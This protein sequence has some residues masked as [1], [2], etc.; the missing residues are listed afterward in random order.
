M[1]VLWQLERNVSIVGAALKWEGG[2]T[3]GKIYDP[4]RCFRPSNIIAVFSCRCSKWR[5]RPNPPNR[6]NSPSCLHEQWLRVISLSLTFSKGTVV[7]KSNNW[8][9]VMTS[10][11]FFIH[12]MY[13]A[14]DRLVISV[15]FI[16]PTPTFRHD[17]LLFTKSLTFL[18]TTSTQNTLHS[19]KTFASMGSMATRRLKFSS[20][21][22]VWPI[23][24]SYCHP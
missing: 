19:L 7:W 17:Q 10:E 21:N 23:P 2:F 13:P 20:P 24:R 18:Q 5:I 6:M 16:P 22:R 11:P 1:L 15:C 4:Y 8:A 3:W 12:K 9:T 14:H